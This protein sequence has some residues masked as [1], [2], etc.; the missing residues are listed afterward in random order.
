MVLPFDTPSY[1]DMSLAPYVEYELPLQAGGNRIEVRTLPTL[2]VYEG[3]QER[4][5]VS[6]DGGEA[7]TFN[8]HADDFS[9]VWR[10]N[11]L[12][13]YASSSIGLRLDE[14][15]KHTLRIYLMDPGIVLQEIRIYCDGTV[16]DF[17]YF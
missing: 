10:K 4:F 8:I 5:A 6:L 14:A 11:V 1:D 2:H 16:T 9:S 17:P 7:T 13:G 3:R 12:Q 15:G